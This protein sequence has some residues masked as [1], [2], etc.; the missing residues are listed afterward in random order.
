M[1]K[2]SDNFP[3]VSLYQS[4]SRWRITTC[5]IGGR[6][7]T[8]R[9][10]I[11][12]AHARRFAA[13]ASEWIQQWKAR[14]ITEGKLLQLLGESL[15]VDGVVDQYRASLK[16]KALNPVYVN[17]VASR[18]RVLIEAMEV[19]K[20]KHITAAALGRGLDK[21]RTEGVEGR[22]LSDQTISHYQTA[23]RQFT[24]W[25]K[26]S[27]LI[28]IDPLADTKGLGV[29]EKVH[30]RR[31]PTPLEVSLLVNYVRDQRRGR[32]LMDGRA[33]GVLYLM[34][35]STGY[36]VG[37]L[38]SVRRS[39]IDFKARLLK[40]P[41]EFTK[42]GKDAIQPLPAWLTDELAFWS[43]EADLLWPEMPNALTHMLR[44]DQSAAREAWIK[45]ASDDH[46]EVERRQKSDTL[47]YRTDS[48]VFDF[49]AFRHFYVTTIGRS[50][51]TVKDTQTLARHSTPMLT[52]GVYS[53]SEA[54][55]LRGVIDEAFKNPLDGSG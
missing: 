2:L 27:H 22:Q 20:L 29:A 10:G 34:A 6:R 31:V 11:S 36:R 26:R 32:F 53:H 45:A 23:M 41:G 54:E 14:L 40:V 48:G 24:K 35:M 50:G 25:L 44:A 39:W 13:T 42:N 8:R 55:A 9:L 3:Y 51:A 1:P 7:I 16:T 43:M 18:V 4:G 33:R 5:R 52:L 30:S 19:S 37:E 17:N 12:A 46:A 47:L 28:E 49:H 38:R 15:S 21:L